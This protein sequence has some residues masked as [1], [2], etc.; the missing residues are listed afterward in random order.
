MKKIFVIGLVFII[1]LSLLTSC[2]GTGKYGIVKNLIDAAGLGSQE[3]R[4]MAKDI[5][6]ATDTDSSKWPADR[7]PIYLPPYPN[8]NFMV[9]KEGE[10]IG[11]SIQD[12]DMD[13]LEKYVEILKADGW[14]VVDGMVLDILLYYDAIKDGWT[15]RLTKSTS[16]HIVILITELIEKEE[17]LQ[18]VRQPDITV[19]P[20]EVIL[21]NDMVTIKYLRNEPILVT[22]MN[23][24]FEVTNHTDTDF[25]LKFVET[26]IDGVMTDTFYA[27]KTIPADMTKSFEILFL[28]RFAEGVG[29]KLEDLKNLQ[30]TIIGVPNRTSKDELFDVT[31]IINLK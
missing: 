19:G 29:H 2:A 15:L 5:I 26:A 18:P 24:F 31:T 17:I 12:T 16:S 21:D 27:E 10:S 14:D 30:L 1:T 20:N 8:G 7:L 11:V 9:I 28:S 3:Q 6:D 25:T 13:T 4:D 22:D 23:I